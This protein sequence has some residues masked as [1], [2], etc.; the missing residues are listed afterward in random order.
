LTYIPEYRKTTNGL[1]GVSKSLLGACQQ[2]GITAIAESEKNTARIRIMQGPPYTE[3]E[4]YYILEYCASDVLETVELF[5]NMI[6]DSNFDT[7]RALLRGRYMEAVAT[8]E[9]NG[10]PIDVG[11]LNALKDNWTQIQEKLIQDIDR[12]YGVYEGTTF[13]ISKFEQYL[14]KNSIAWP[15]TEKG[16]LELK[17]GTFKDMCLRYPQLQGLK[18][19]T[20]CLKTKFYS[21][22]VIKSSTIR[23]I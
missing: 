8:M 10:I 5:R 23:Q 19:L 9:H 4:K 3:E 12:N 6:V 13:K 22:I 7:P 2:Y 20:G 15:R 11:T 17:D 1:P 21:T 16:N 18:D 14:N